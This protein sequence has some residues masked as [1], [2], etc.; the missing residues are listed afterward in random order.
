VRF[1]QAV[2]FLPT[3]H[4]LAVARAADDQGY[5][6]ISLSDH[7]FFPRHRQSRYTYSTADD[8]APFWESETEWPDV[9]CL[10]SAMAAIT[11]R[12]RFTTGVYVAPARDLITVAKQVGTAAVLS[13]NRVNLGV[14]VGWCKE[15]F[16]ATGQDFHTRGKRLDDMI[17]ALRALWAG[18]WV[19]YHGPH[20]DVPALRMEPSPTAPIPVICG[21]HSTPAFRRAAALCDGW[22]AAG[23]YE[24]DEARRH[25][26][27]LHEERRRIGRTGEPFSVFLSLWS[28]PDVDLYRSFE[29]DY[30]VT[31]MLSGAAM[32]AKVDPSDP[33]EAQLQTRIDASARF[34]EEVMEKMR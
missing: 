11:T 7:M 16:D 29:E 19:E 9:W 33:P 17:P 31:D 12:V 10:I 21:G 28:N 26:T 3:H 6:G 23:A 4:Q 1:H 13:S 8:G 14:G 25:L 18:G 34:A 2:A 22:M 30:G 32:A 20:Y 24:P 5:D 27:A 15:E